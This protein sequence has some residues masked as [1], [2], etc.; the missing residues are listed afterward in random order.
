[1]LF[2]PSNITPDEING[3]GCV[4]ISQGLTVSW[5]VN[6]DSA[7]TAYRIVIYRNNAA[8]TQLYST[9][10]VALSTPFWGVNYR[11]ETQFFTASIGASA[12]SGAGLANGNEYKFIIT[13]WWSDSDS[14][15]QTTASLFL[16]RS[17]PGVSV[18][19]IPAP[20]TERSYSFTGTYTQAQ[21]DALRWV[22]W[23]IAAAGS[24]SSPFLD[25]GEIGGTGQLRV[26]YDGFFTGTQYSIQL[27]VETE[28]GIAASSGWVNFSVEYE[29]TE[30][31]GRVTVCQ[32]QDSSAVFVSWDM[33]EAAQ[34]YDIFRRRAG[35]SVLVKLASVDD[36]T[37]QLRDYS[38]SSGQSYVYYVFPTGNLA[39]LTEPMVSDELAVNFWFWSIVEATV[40]DDGSYRVDK[41]HLFRYGSG[42]VQEGSFSNNN[43]PQV[44]KN[45]T[46]YPTRQGETADYLTGSVSGYIGTIGSD[47]GRS[48]SDTLEQARA[49]RALS[50]TANALFLLDPK[51]HFIRIATS[52]EVTMTINH[53]SPVRP[54]TV[55]VPWVEVDDASE[56]SL[57]AA[58]GGD[59]YPVD[60][61][62]FTT[63]RVDPVSG[64]LL[65]NRDADYADGSRLY[66]QGGVL[67]QDDSGSFTAAS[68]SIN[69]NVLTATLPDN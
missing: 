29:V 43:A 28:N 11:G 22:R 12:L 37:G 53:A 61:V 34:G 41:L 60:E 44:Q 63:V 31:Q 39:Y 52:G 19:A 38:A 25:T 62:I 36:T 33:M 27:S 55:T 64:Q 30:P 13:Q 40:Q 49:F 50:T 24:E 10:R 23:Q 57:V 58:P 26:D 15:Q 51:G 32:L 16:T 69:G 8:S 6:G 35:D 21:G 54:T 14:I 68:M 7:M 4:D 56:V 66:L 45:F 3:S 17:T 1:M 47:G 2:Q 48:Y 9:G 59:F 67:Y 5:Q 42:G 46:R 65:W 18:N 20:L